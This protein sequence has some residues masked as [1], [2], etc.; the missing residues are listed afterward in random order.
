M[1]QGPHV[2]VKGRLHLLPISPVLYPSSLQLWSPL[3]LAQPPG[4]N[5]PQI[6]RRGCWDHPGSCR[7]DESRKWPESGTTKTP[8]PGFQSR[9]QTAPWDFGSYQGCPPSG[10]WSFISHK[11]SGLPKDSDARDSSLLNP[12]SAKGSSLGGGGLSPLLPMHLSTASLISLLYL[13]SPLPPLSP[14]S[15]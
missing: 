12:D 10:T 13:G 14:R 15:C 11:A 5:E 1:P 4:Y 7:G 3:G 9:H 2:K 6:L 8:S